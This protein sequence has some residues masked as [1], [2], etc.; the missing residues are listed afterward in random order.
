V[1]DSV[2]AFVTEEGGVCLELVG[3]GGRN[4]TFKTWLEV[5]SPGCRMAA[6]PAIRVS[7]FNYA[8]FV[9]R[10]GEAALL[11]YHDRRCELRPVGINTGGGLPR[12]ASTLALPV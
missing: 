12:R 11:S 4:A 1:G 7:K 3:V 6:A 10:P 2:T 5:G 8:A 9:L